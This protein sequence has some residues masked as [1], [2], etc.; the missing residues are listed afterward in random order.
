MLQKLWGLIFKS[1]G[2]EGKKRSQNTLM[3][4]SLLVM[5]GILLILWS[6]LTT[7]KK[8]DLPM[9]PKN[10]VQPTISSNSPATGYEADLET[11]LERI[12]S[13]IDGVGKV[14]IK[15]T[16]E[17]TKE[18]IY[19]YNSSVSESQTD[20]N[21]K[22]GGIRNMKEYSREQDLVVL[23]DQDGQERPVTQTEIYPEIKGVLVVAQGAENPKTNAEL[24][25]AVNTVLGV[26]LHDICIL[27]YKR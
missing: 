9:E 24:M 26:D 27:P 20:E 18:N 1:I 3:Y 22:A 13:L 2:E 25:R 7:T 15:I 8:V 14:E 12:L 4:L 17:Q 10:Q 16:F 21:D 11:S 6:N 23:R 5:L 19:L